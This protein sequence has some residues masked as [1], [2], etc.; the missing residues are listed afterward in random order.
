M[1]TAVSKSSNHRD[2]SLD[3]LRFFGVLIIIY[4]HTHPPEW[5]DQIRNFGTP[6]LIVASAATY[7]YIY[8]SRE[9]KVVAFL[10]KR[11]YRLLIPAWTFLTF[12]FGSLLIV[13]IVL[14]RP[15][16]FNTS[17]I[18]ESYLLYR[19]IGYVWIFKVYLYL[20]FLTPLL[21]AYTRIVKND[22]LYYGSLV[23]FFTIY[24]IASQYFENTMSERSFDIFADYVL[25]IFP[26]LALY[27]YGMRLHELKR[28]TVGWVALLSGIICAG[29]AIYLYQRTGAWVP[30][31]EYKYPPQLYYLSYALMW[32]N[33]LYLVAYSPLIKSIPPK[34][35]QWL[36]ENS[37]WIYLWHICAVYGLERVMEYDKS[38]PVTVIRFFLILAISIGLVLIQNQITKRV[39]LL[40]VLLHGSRRIQKMKKVA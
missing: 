21:L 26:Y 39:E 24:S 22:L 11:M 38:I 10:E 7:A 18:V 12:F 17:T 34:I 19:G 1:N 2:H 28:S 27:G 31:Q 13:S 29:I 9:L 6:L 5:I 23:L 3:F 36:S 4:A 37:L 25:T 33:I 30:T 8:R 16:P 20:A 40:H 14:D 32:V 15:Y 35:I